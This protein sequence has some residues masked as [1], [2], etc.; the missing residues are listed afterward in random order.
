ML[1]IPSPGMAGTGVNAW[2][3]KPVGKHPPL[4]RAKQDGI[5]ARENGE[6]PQASFSAWNKYK[7]LKNGVSGKNDAYKSQDSVTKKERGFS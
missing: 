4:S 3:W 1:P 7:G 2:P 5:P 6:Q